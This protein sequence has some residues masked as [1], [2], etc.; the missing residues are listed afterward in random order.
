MLAALGLEV[1]GA[2]DASLACPTEWS[3]RGADALGDGGPWLGLNPGAAFGTAKRWLPERFAAVAQ[4]V[5]RRTGAKVAIVGGPAERP[6]AEA[7]AGG[8]RAPVRALCGET[9]L[10]EL[11]GGLS[12]LPLLVT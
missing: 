1:S 6:L 8:V 9:T 2:P 12:P 10:P 5:S 7:I 11:V 4:L 3:A